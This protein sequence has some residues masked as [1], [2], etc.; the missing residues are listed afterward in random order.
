MDVLDALTYML[1]KSGKSKAEVAESIGR[2]PNSVYNMF[3]RKTDVRVDTLAAMAE[4]MGYE[5]ILR[6]GEDEVKVT[7][8]A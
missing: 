1:E 8:R 6:N 2:L 5:L 4:C 3:S 7:P